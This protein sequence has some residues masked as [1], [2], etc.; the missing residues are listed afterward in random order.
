MQRSE[1]KIHTDRKQISVGQELGEDDGSDGLMSVG[2]LWQ[3]LIMFY[4]GW[5]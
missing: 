5:W 2:F 3:V 4:R 1:W